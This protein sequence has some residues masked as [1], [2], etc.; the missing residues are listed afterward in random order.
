MPPKPP[1]SIRL[2][3]HL[4]TFLSTYGEDNTLSG[5]ITTLLERYK[6]ITADACPEFTE[7]EW[8]AIVDA[9]NGFGVWLTSGIDP[10]QILWANVYDPELDGIDEKWGVSCRDLADRIRA[11][12]L[13]GKAAVW[14]VAARFWAS[15]RLNEISALDLLKEAGAKIKEM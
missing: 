13:A 8:C 11:L 14:D 15:P 5:S 2:P 12:P 10:Y 7:A 9:N 4:K 1:T 3:E 6:Q